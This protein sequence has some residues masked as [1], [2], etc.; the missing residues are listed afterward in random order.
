MSERHLMLSYKRQPLRVALESDGA[1]LPADDVCRALGLKDHKWPMGRLSESEKSLRQ[2]GGAGPRMRVVSVEGA[3]RLAGTVRGQEGMKFLDWFQERAM[4]EIAVAL[5]EIADA[6]AAV[7]DEPVAPM[8]GVA[9]PDD[10]VA[11]GAVVLDTGHSFLYDKLPV[12]L[13]VD[14]IGEILFNAND[15]CEALEL[16]NP[17]KAV[18]D[19][20]D[21]DD[22]TRSDTIDA[23]GRNQQANYVN[24]SGLYALVFG[25]KKEAARRFK[26]WV[27]HDVLPSIQ[28]TGS[29]SL[30]GT[31]QSESPAVSARPTKAQILSSAANTAALSASVLGD[32][33]A[34]RI[35]IQARAALAKI[36]QAEGDL[37][38]MRVEVQ[39]KSGLEHPVA[40][41]AYPEPLL[42]RDGRAVAGAAFS[43]R[44][45]LIEFGGNLDRPRA[46]PLLS[47]EYLVKA[48]LMGVKFLANRARFG[49]DDWT[50]LESLVQYKIRAERNRK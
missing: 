15:V 18:D 33:A 4:P 36:S 11:S 46:R 41:A 12:R 45:Y 31:V 6:L 35:Q 19:H 44:V 13:K 16:S 47:G 39:F 43:G 17:R 25:S 20:C 2:I 3:R 26:R 34:A 30:T 50:E 8:L 24:L 1:W 28:K 14:A 48:N 29:Y 23:M 21:P 22:V 49:L 40:Y 37:R 9:A 38:Q 5:R 42:T 7:Q 10:A 27:T 32:E